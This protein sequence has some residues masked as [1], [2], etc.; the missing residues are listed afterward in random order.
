MSEKALT[1]VSN[2]PNSSEMISEKA[3]NIY[4]GLN[5]NEMM[6]ATI[7]V[8]AAGAENTAALAAV[9]TDKNKDGYNSCTFFQSS[10][11]QEF[12]HT[13]AVCI[14]TMPCYV[15]IVR[16]HCAKIHHL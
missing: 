15:C 1:A 6:I 5:N 11:R 9:L 13:I 14:I 12:H 16:I 7:A 4:N 3:T 8:A 2:G 10:A